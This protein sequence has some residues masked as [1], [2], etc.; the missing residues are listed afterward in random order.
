[1]PKKHE[2]LLEQLRESQKGR[3]RADLESLYKGFGFRIQTASGG[4]D[5]V[6]HPD[7]PSLITSLPRHRNILPYLVREAVRLVDEL[8]QL[9][10][11]KEEEAKRAQEAK[12]NDE[13][14]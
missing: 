2:K 1:M 9:Q 6:T 4:H 7:F 11:E 5:K 10:N 14:S 8:K 12:N 3:K 13:Q